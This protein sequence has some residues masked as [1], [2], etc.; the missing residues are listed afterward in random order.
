MATV[1]TP[2]MTAVEFFDFVHRPE[3][4]DRVFELEAGEI[5]EMSRPGKKHGL[6]CANV[7]RILGNYAAASK[8]GYVCSN[9]T[10]VVVE[11]NPDTVRGPDVMFFEDVATFDDVETKFGE[12]PPLLAV[13]VLSPN[14]NTGKVN[15]RIEQ[16]LAFGAG[17]VW[18]LDPESLTVTVYRNDRRHVVFDETD[19]L[20]GADILPEFRCKVSEFFSMPG[21]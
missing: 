6:V 3:N 2:P 15:R 13:E 17:M 16:Q 5:V 12:T 19:E 11:R 8:K 7:A 9:D 21:R 10:G 14:D 20:T 18:L 1:A 4:R